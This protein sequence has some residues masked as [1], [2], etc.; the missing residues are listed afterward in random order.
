ME[1]K[2]SANHNENNNNTDV[3]TKTMNT[4][5][6]SYVISTAPSID[7]NSIYTE[8]ASHFYSNTTPPISTVHA[9]NDNFKSFASFTSFSNSNSP[10]SNTCIKNSTNTTKSASNLTNS[11]INSS[12]KKTMRNMFSYSQIE[13][14]E[15]IFEQT[16]YPDSTM[17]EKLSGHL[18]INSSRIQ[19]WFQNRRAKV[20]W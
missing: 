7:S 3:L 18:G 15:N 13:I 12:S 16:H 6:S 4:K 19:V 1:H 17:R 20:K 2:S 8:N 5:P 10:E 14:L 11:S 9:N